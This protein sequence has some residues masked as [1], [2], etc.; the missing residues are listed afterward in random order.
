M[1]LY[2]LLEKQI[3]CKV[4]YYRSHQHNPTRSVFLCQNGDGFIVSNELWDNQAQKIQLDMNKLQKKKVIFI[5]ALLELIRSYNI[6]PIVLL[7][8]VE[9]N[10]VYE[11]SQAVAKELKVKKIINLVN[12][13]NKNKYLWADFRHFN[14][15]GRYHYSKEVI[16]KLK[17]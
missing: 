8:P 5:N 2:S 4:S 12:Y 1:S 16:E 10:K 3:D 7:E 13:V 17:K 9:Y 14:Y 11:N 15:I 6:V